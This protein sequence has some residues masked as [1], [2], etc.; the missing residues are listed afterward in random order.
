MTMRKKRNI[1]NK[2]KRLQ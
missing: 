2:Y 1:Y